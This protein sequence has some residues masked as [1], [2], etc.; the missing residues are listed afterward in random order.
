MKFR[1]DKN[2]DLVIDD[3]SDDLMDETR[4]IA[5]DRRIAL[6]DVW[7]DLVTQ[8]VNGKGQEP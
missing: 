4:Q 6:E 1:F 2:D 5:L 3:I 7:R 8:L